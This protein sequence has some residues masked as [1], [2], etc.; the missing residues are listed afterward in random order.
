MN[1]AKSNLLTLPESILIEEIL[2]KLPIDYL[3]RL[4]ST[5]NR[6]RNI[7]L[8]ERIWQIK[9]QNDFPDQVII[10]PDTK[11]WRQYYEYLRNFIR[12]ISVE[13]YDG[14]VK[15]IIGD[16]DL[17]RNSTSKSLTDEIIKLVEQHGYKSNDYTIQFLEYKPT[18]V[19]IIGFSNDRNM[20][21]SRI[22]DIKKTTNVTIVVGL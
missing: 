18:Y 19:N 13:Y 10:K 14:H 8:N 20:R 4:C 7:C 3:N 17:M 21:P 9:T 12:K 16:I 6:L 1:N 22:Y 2:P 15:E 11:T 5:N